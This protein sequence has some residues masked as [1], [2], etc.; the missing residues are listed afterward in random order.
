MN[1][2]NLGRN[3][4]VNYNKGVI[5]VIQR[6]EKRDKTQVSIDELYYAKNTECTCMSLIDML[7]PSVSFCKAQSDA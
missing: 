5:A 2:Y 1:R 7:R 3:L 4:A 6:W